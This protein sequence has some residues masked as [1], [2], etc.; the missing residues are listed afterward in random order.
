MYAQYTDLIN[1]LLVRLLNIIKFLKQ[2][3]V[4]KKI[5]FFSYLAAIFGLSFFYSKCVKY[6]M[7]KPVRVTNKL[8]E[9]SNLELD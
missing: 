7:A 1:H 8:N 4:S 6:D 5:F 2:I 3:L 9:H